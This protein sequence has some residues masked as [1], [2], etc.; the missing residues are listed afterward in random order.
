MGQ[1]EV[2]VGILQGHGTF[3]HVSLFRKADGF[4]C[5]PTV[6][7]AHCQVIAFNAKGGD[8]PSLSLWVDVLPDEGF[9]APGH[10]FLDRD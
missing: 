8:M 5:Q 7:Q 9:L 1:A 4:A 6:V 3:Q 2:I 10:F